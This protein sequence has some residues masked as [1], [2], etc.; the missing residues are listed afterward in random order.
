MKISRLGW[1]LLNCISSMGFAADDDI[2]VP[3]AITRCLD[4]SRSNQSV[5]I[6]KLTNPY[7][8]RGDFDADGMPDYAVAVKGTRSGRNGVLFCL[9]R[10]SVIVLGADNSIDRP[11]SDMPGDNF[12]A[13]TW[14]VATRQDVSAFQ[15][16]NKVVPLPKG[17]VILMIWE[18]ARTTSIGIAVDFVGLP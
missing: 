2:A 18:D 17:E 16:T 8:L 13:S 4:R 11:F 3:L 5:T 1:R 14:E 12:V 10:N 15:K 7:Y 9:S 6:N